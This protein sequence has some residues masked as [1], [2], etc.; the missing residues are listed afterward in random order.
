MHIRVVYNNNTYDYVMPF[1]F[2]HLLER[3]KIKSF[4]RYSEERWIQVGV[5]KMRGDGGF[6]NGDERRMVSTS[7]VAK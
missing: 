5:D 6:Y 4:Y 7:M 2:E 1:V 3:D